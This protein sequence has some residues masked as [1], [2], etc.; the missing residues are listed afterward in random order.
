VKRRVVAA[1]F[2]VL[3]LAIAALIASSA[4]AGGDDKGP[5]HDDVR[6]AAR[7]NGFNEVP[8]VSTTGRGLF[9]ARLGGDGA[10]IAYEL[11]YS[12]LETRAQAAHIHFAQR[13]VNGGVIAFLCGGSAP[14]CPESGTVTGT[15]TAANIIGPEAQGIEPGSF[16]EA[17]RALRGGA[18]YANV[19]STRF[20]DGEI[21]GQVRTF[22]FGD[23]D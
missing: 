23:K 13:H 19:H 1:S 10:S 12:G 17:V 2:S 20:P 16:A 7:L 14:P 21:R 9:V 18:V 15:L 4:L 5:A 11:T 8:S 22:H 3:V 6:F